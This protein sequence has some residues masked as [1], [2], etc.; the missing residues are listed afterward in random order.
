LNRGKLIKNWQKGMRNIFLEKV[1]HNLDL[2]NK[3]IKL[4]RP[5]HFRHD[6]TQSVPRFLHILVD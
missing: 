1:P 4:L 2:L 3:R 6:W 5:L